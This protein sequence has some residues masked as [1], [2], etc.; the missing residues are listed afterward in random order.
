MLI[1]LSKLFVG[2]LTLYICNRVISKIPSHRFRI[3]MYKQLMNFKIGKG[4][5]V[6][7]NC[8]FDCSRNF[9]IGQNSVI[10]SGCRLDNR[11]TIIIGDNVSISQEV[12]ILTADHDVN[13]T[14]GEGILKKVILEDYS[15]IGTRAL[16]LPGVT[17]KK[18]A[19][20]A[21]GAIVTKDVEEYSIVVGVP[22]KHIKYR[23]RNLQYSASYKR[24]FQ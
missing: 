19:V 10:N 17:I 16:I 21:A 2:E 6:F 22:A 14:M 9:I 23:N 18:G 20:V 12:I 7:M 1:K 5:T 4:S 3:F 8:S 11:G 15:W 13:S 24:W